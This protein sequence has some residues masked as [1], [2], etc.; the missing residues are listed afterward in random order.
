MIVKDVPEGKRGLEI[1][2][3]L[4]H[5]L[6]GHKH[7]FSISSIDKKK[8]Y[9]LFATTEDSKL[10]WLRAFATAKDAGGEQAQL[11]VRFFRKATPKLIFHKEPKSILYCGGGT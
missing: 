8:T 3:Y 11:P 2:Y 1:A 7:A 4:S 5:T 10:L 9:V 6:S